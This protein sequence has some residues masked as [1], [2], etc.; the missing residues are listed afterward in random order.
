MTKKHL[1]YDECILYQTQLMKHNGVRL[2][3]CDT[4]LPLDTK[5]RCSLLHPIIIMNYMLASPSILIIP[6]LSSNTQP[7]GC[8]KRKEI[9]YCAST[10]LKITFQGLSKG[11]NQPQVPDIW[12]S[13]SGFLNFAILNS[14]SGT[15]IWTKNG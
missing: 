14:F 1:N 8:S 6:L 13:K 2:I 10:Q 4:T 7:T 3:G 12:S 9:K 15:C 5:N 11:S